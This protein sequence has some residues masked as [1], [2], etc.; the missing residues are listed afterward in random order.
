MG[1]VLSRPT[2]RPTDAPI[3]E[4]AIED[5][6]KAYLKAPARESAAAKGIRQKAVVDGLIGQS[7]SFK[8][9]LGREEVNK[10]GK[11][12]IDVVDDSPIRTIVITKTRDSLT[13]I[14]IGKDISVG[15]EII[16]VEVLPAGDRDINGKTVKCPPRIDIRVK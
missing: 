6:I 2:T 10:K 5:A 8:G 16:G 9:K 15:G 4:K 14:K 12:E 7:V 11:I 1:C 13:G 3:G